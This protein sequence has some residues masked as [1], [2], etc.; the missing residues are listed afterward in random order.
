MVR[1]IEGWERKVK[2]RDGQ[3][4][5]LLKEGEVVGLLEK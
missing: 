5:K 1:E 3:I 4:E 2:E